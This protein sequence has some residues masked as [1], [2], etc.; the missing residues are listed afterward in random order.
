MVHQPIRADQL[1]NLGQWG[2]GVTTIKSIC[3]WMDGALVAVALLD[4]VEL[5]AKLG[6]SGADDRAALPS[7]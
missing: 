4:Q 5:G 6:R 3:T 1:A 7:A 2:D